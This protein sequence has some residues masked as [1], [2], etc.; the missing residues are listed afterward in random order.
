MRRVSLPIP[1]GA[2]AQL[3]ECLNGIQEVAG[4]IPAGSTT[5]ILGMRFPA[6]APANPLPQGPV[7]SEP[8]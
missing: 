8:Q 2:V 3:G 4:S 1:C 6:A 5:Q 7:V